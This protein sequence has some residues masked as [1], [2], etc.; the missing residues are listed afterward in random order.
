MANE[1][2]DNRSAQNGANADKQNQDNRPN[3]D[4]QNDNRQGNQPSWRKEIPEP[5]EEAKRAIEAQGQNNADKRRQN[6]RPNR[7][8]NQNADKR[9]DAPNNRD[10]QSRE[11]YQQERLEKQQEILKANLGKSQVIVQNVGETRELASLAIVL[12]QRFAYIRA[13]M[14]VRLPGEYGML[15]LYDLQEALNG[16]RGV[17]HRLAI[18]GVKKYSKG[19]G[20]NRNDNRPTLNSE[21]IKRFH[22]AKLKAFVEQG[23]KLNESLRALGYEGDTI[24]QTLKDALAD[25]EAKRQAE[26]DR[27]KTEQEAQRVEKAKLKAERKAEWE[28]RQ[29]EIAKQKRQAKQSDGSGDQGE[30]NANDQSNANAN[31]RSSLDRLGDQGETPSLTGASEP[32]AKDDQEAKP[33]KKKEKAA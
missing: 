18:F 20:K 9:S 2:Q 29:E 25:Y 21:T 17:E 3:A 13:N 7:Q 32:E 33:S 14:F 15:A 8:N 22:Y 12:D 26:A 19:K 28:A 23:E 5:R 16:L 24:A 10:N 11:A 4:R 6:N 27:I 30:G 31:D 1:N